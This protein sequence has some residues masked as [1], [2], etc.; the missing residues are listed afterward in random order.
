MHELFF[1]T[2]TAL[3][4]RIIIILM[5]KEDKSIKRRRVA[6]V[7]SSPQRITC[8]SDLPVEPLSYVANFLTA[9]SRALFA[10]AFEESF[11]I[12]SNNQWTTAIAGNQ[13]DVL[14]FGEI[15]TELAAKMSDDDIEKVLLCIDAVNTLKR[16]KLTNCVN[17]TG[18]GLRPLRGSAMIEQI[19]LSLVGDHQNPILS[20][21]PAIAGEIVLPILDSIISREGNLKHLH[22]PHVWRKRRPIDSEFYA[23]LGRCNQMWGNGD[24]HLCLE[25][26]EVLPL[27]GDNWFET[28][29]QSHMFGVQNNTCGACLKLYCIHCMSDDVVDGF[30]IDFCQ[31]CD[32]N[33]CIECSAIEFCE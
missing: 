7:D 2:H 12:S 29:N 18:A 8:L 17:I 32:R 23:F 31:T 14:D 22:F 6:A 20:P 26:E 11:G 4:F 15:E 10:V 30:M 19:D 28:Q 24:T 33:Y 16:M 21:E 25:C 1:C 5:A 27:T 9:P 3:S 13:W